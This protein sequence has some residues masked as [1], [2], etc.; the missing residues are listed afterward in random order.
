MANATKALK[1]PKPF[2]SLARRPD[3]EWLSK[4]DTP[5]SSTKRWAETV[6]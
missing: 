3:K 1:G 5:L 2:D 6:T 4:I